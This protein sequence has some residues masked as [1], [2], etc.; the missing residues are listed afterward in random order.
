LAWLAPS[1]GLAAP[2]GATVAAAQVGKP[3]AASSAEDSAVRGWA[4]LEQLRA[5]LRAAGPQVASFRQTF[6]PA[7]FE[8]GERE[9]GRLAISLPKCMRWDY[10][11]DFAKSYLLCD[12][13]AYTWNPGEP[14]G[15]RTRV[16][17][18]LALEAPGLDF[19]LLTI[20]QLRA[21]YE[22]AAVGEATVGSAT[23]IE[24]ELIPVNA[25]PE[26]TVL[27]VVLGAQARTVRRLSY[28]DQ[29]GNRTTF[30]IYDYERGVEPGSFAAP[31]SLE[32]EDS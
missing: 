22:L 5:S 29:E 23:E 11:G 25:T 6:V 24:L 17:D 18:E 9:E 21:R 28:V 14:K 1:S 16:D 31:A 32:W 8:E 10:A 20:E 19:F 2:G 12:D 13:W 15:R 3:S 7:G 30:E 27:R 26:V 4:A